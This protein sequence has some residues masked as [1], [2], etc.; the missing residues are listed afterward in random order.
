MTTRI[1]TAARNAACDAAVDLLDADASAGY[2]EIRTGTQPATVATAASGTLLATCTLGDPAFGASGAVN[3]GEAVA[4]AVA[5]V[6]AVADGTAGW[7]RGYDGAGVAVIDGA[8]GAGLEME[9]NSYVL[10]TGLD[11]TIDSWTVTMPSGEA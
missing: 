9:L 1:P 8:V 5:T 3:P 7:F 6:Q 4:N 11:V 10:N 2:V